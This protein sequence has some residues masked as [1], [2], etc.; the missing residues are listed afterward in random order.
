[1]PQH[2]IGRIPF[3]GKPS[4][5]SKGT[6]P[7][8]GS[9]RAFSQERPRPRSRWRKGIWGVDCGRITTP[10]SKVD[11]KVPRL[12]RSLYRPDKGT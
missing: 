9:T 12:N 11:G 5:A 1:M 3:Q 2:E 6:K 8:D 7:T 4:L 10:R